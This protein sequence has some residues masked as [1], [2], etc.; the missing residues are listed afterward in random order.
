MLAVSPTLPGSPPDF[1]AVMMD[2][3]YRRLDVQPVSPVAKHVQEQIQINVSLVM[4]Q[5]LSGI[6]NVFVQME[7]TLTKHLK[8]VFLV[9]TIVRLAPVKTS[10]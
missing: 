2:S 7:V 4:E 3:T 8:A 1:A 6:V 5:L 10:V 9:R